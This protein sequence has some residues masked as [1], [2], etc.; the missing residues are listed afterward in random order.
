MT[1]TEWDFSYPLT[2]I[3]L[4]SKVKDFRQ[5]EGPLDLKITFP[6]GRVVQGT[7]GRGARAEALAT[8]DAEPQPVD[9]VVLLESS[10][11]DIEALRA[12]ADR[13]VEAWGPARGTEGDLQD[14][15]DRTAEIMETDGTN[16]V[17]AYPVGRNVQRFEADQ[18]DGISP[19][20]GARF[21]GDVVTIRVVLKFEPAAG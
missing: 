19:S 17:K 12:S 18:Q 21:N 6:S 7:W 3:D 1:L 4:G 15:A 16:L 9:S 13:F 10:V 5:P 11:T 20:W 14:F 2:P 8:S